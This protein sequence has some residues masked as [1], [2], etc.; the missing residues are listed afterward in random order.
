MPGA[1]D[2]INWLHGRIQMVVVSDTFSE[3]ADPQ[4]EKI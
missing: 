2:F 3:F 4:L 1:M